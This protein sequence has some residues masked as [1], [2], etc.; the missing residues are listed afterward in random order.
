MNV[1]EHQQK[2]KINIYN[3]RCLSPNAEKKKLNFLPNPMFSKNPIKL[4]QDE[5]LDILP[6]PNLNI[7]KAES[8]SS[9]SLLDS[10][11][12]RNSYDSE[13]ILQTQPIVKREENEQNIAF[14]QIHPKKKAKYFDVSYPDKHFCS[15]CALDIFI[16][17]KQ[18][19][20]SEE[21]GTKRAQIQ[22]FLNGICNM[23]S[24]LK[25]QKKRIINE[26][27]NIEESKI[28]QEFYLNDFF[29]NIKSTIQDQQTTYHDS[30]KQSFTSLRRIFLSKVEKLSNFEVEMEELEKDIKSNYSNIIKLMDIDP[31]YE[32]MYRY[33]SKVN[34]IR[35]VFMTIKNQPAEIP[36]NPLRV[37][38]ESIHEG[39]IKLISKRVDNFLS[40]SKDSIDTNSEESYYKNEKKQ[41]SD[42]KEKPNTL[43][44]NFLDENNGLNQ[45]E[46]KS[47]QN[48]VIE[49][50]KKFISKIDFCGDTNGLFFT[51]RE[52][53]CDST[54]QTNHPSSYFESKHPYDKNMSNSKQSNGKNYQNDDLKAQAEFLIRS[55]DSLISHK[56][57]MRSKSQ[58]FKK[59]PMNNLNF[60]TEALSHQY[61]QTHANFKTSKDYKANNKISY[62]SNIT[63][64][65]MTVNPSSCNPP[66]SQ[67]QLYLTASQT[68]TI[69]D[70]QLDNIIS[71]QRCERPSENQSNQIES[72]M[73]K[74]AIS[75]LFSTNGDTGSKMDISPILDQKNKIDPRIVN[76]MNTKSA[77]QDSNLQRNNENQINK[78]EKTK[79]QNMIYKTESPNDLQKY[80][81]QINTNEKYNYEK[82][83]IDNMTANS[84]SVQIVQS[85][86]DSQDSSL[87]MDTDRQFILEGPVCTPPVQIMQNNFICNINSKTTNN[88]N[89]TQN[90]R[91]TSDNERISDRVK[92]AMMSNYKFKNIML[93]NLNN[94][95]SA[96]MVN[97]NVNP[98][99]FNK[100]V[101]LENNLDFYNEINIKTSPQIAKK[102][103]GQIYQDKL[104]TCR[105][106]KNTG[107]KL[108]GFF[109]TTSSNFNRNPS[110]GNKLLNN[111]SET[112]TESCS[113]MYLKTCNDRSNPKVIN[114]MKPYTISTITKSSDYE[115]K[116]KA[117]AQTKM[118]THFFSTQ[119]L[120]KKISSKT[121]NSE[122]SQIKTLEEKVLEASQNHNKKF[123]ES[124]A[125]RDVRIFNKRNSRNG[126]KN[127]TNNVATKKNNSDYKSQNQH[128]IKSID[129]DMKP[130]INRGIEILSKRNSKSSK[131]IEKP[132]FQLGNH[133]ALNRIGEKKMEENEIQIVPATKSLSDSMKTKFDP[134]KG[135]IKTSKS[136]TSRNFNKNSKENFPSNN[137][138]VNS[139]KFEQTHRDETNF[140]QKKNTALNISNRNQISQQIIF[141]NV[142]PSK[143]EINQSP[144][145]SNKLPQSKQLFNHNSDEYLKKNAG[146]SIDALGKISKPKSL[147]VNTNQHNSRELVFVNESNSLNK[148]KK[149]AKHER[150][151]Y[152]YKKNKQLNDKPDFV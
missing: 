78:F 25:Q 83:I 67:S 53:N 104:L 59:V 137:N 80:N 71:T 63:M 2:G 125:T 81:V 38:N 129:L 42:Q 100:Q 105:K 9:G 37:K 14:C 36:E 47:M 45:L 73:H 74:Q 113:S 23:N 111:N 5:S 96:T 24:E 97:T 131:Q 58:S 26:I 132:K 54:T 48:L 13:N 99:I 85:H 50:T 90:T 112:V 16:N 95:P 118:N 3:S 149:L 123:S 56:D 136:K 147:T 10:E 31:F 51:P 33:N 116:A 151:L 19:G 114:K 41:D 135:S 89:I 34:K 46:V 68:K 43:W 109:N 70:A 65:P 102:N 8:N 108:Q 94:K 30:I 11:N 32:I 72:I 107:N 88:N 60:E 141:G 7:I 127:S 4:N 140:S 146:F 117:L 152:L 86:L 138:S 103:M 76:Y 15:K 122:N 28:K 93:N 39:F 62:D 1:N 98:P 75:N 40:D 17:N 133:S 12:Q 18:T 69:I 126:N 44:D 57:D 134:Y 150:L 82:A 29:T 128:E 35:Q 20:C 145:L 64:V 106:L 66:S 121:L 77:S 27:K 91:E 124:N 120:E 148:S 87:K 143:T 52:K 61:Y 92:N 119:A 21:E 6:D 101:S 115:E 49:P 130:C 139:N 110:A 79:N 22:D 142:Y 55:V 144:N 84:Q